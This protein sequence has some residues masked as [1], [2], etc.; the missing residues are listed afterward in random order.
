MVKEAL[1][2]EL[3]LAHGRPSSHAKWLY[4]LE[5]MMRTT[6][7]CPDRQGAG[8]Q[9]DQQDVADGVPAGGRAAVTQSLEA[10]DIQADKQRGLITVWPQGWS[11]AWR[12][13]SRPWENWLD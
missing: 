13:K 8:V 3:V 5:R 4:L 2:W 11:W 10:G 7:G 12:T 9:V 6:G 1:K